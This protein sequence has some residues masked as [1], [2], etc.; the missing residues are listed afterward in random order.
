MIP[1]EY[2]SS[3]FVDTKIKNHILKYLKYDQI[4]EQDNT[5]LYYITKNETYKKEEISKIFN[6]IQNVRNLTNNYKPLKIYIYNTNLKKRLPKNKNHKLG[7]FEINSGF[8]TH[9]N[10]N[11]NGDVVIFRKEELDKV[12]IHELLHSFKSD[13]NIHPYK[14]LNIS[15]S[16][17][18]FLAIN[19][20][21]NLF[22]SKKKLHSYIKYN[23]M[24]CAQI[25]QYY[26]NDFNKVE[27]SLKVYF[28]YKGVLFDN[29]D[30]TWKFISKNKNLIFQEQYNDEYQQLL[31]EN[32]EKYMKKIK[33]LK[34]KKDMDRS[35]KMINF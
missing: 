4:F 24:K 15:E 25:L 2:L 6:I 28:F 29:F 5:I 3:F 1:Q 17:I 13:W 34:L 27:D 21:I 35:L 23:E 22:F 9:Y 33:K 11:L 12:L 16:Y 19:I 32:F 14:N 7:P 30:K 18:D 26:N 8:T 20:Y 31:E 10:P